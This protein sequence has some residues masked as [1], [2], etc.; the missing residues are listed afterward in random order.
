MAISDYQI[1]QPYRGERSYFRRDF[2]RPTG[3]YDLVFLA[4]A[5]D[6]SP[7]FNGKYH[8]ECSCCWLHFAHSEE[9]HRQAIERAK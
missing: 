8:P 2:Y 3:N 6:L 4:G 9:K 7:I 1:G 5:N